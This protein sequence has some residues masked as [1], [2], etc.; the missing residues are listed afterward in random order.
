MIYACVICIL[1]HIV[2]YTTLSMLFT[3]FLIT[4]HHSSS[5][6]AF[7]F[8][9]NQPTQSP[10]R[11]RPNWP[12]G[13]ICYK[14][15]CINRPHQSRIKCALW[16]SFASLLLTFS[17]RSCGPGPFMYKVF[18]Q[19]TP[20]PYSTQLCHTKRNALLVT[21]SWFSHRR[22]NQQ[23]ST[24]WSLLFGSIIISINSTNDWERLL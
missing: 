23:H 24:F 21:W 2:R 4:N 12:N 20:T 17:D 6:S 5:I 22:P 15:P 7:A 1:V 9:L 16:H 11:A 10:A 14:L 8:A 18:D 3:L 13:P 19:S